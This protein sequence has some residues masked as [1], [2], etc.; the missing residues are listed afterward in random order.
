MFA[1]TSEAPDRKYGMACHQMLQ[2]QQQQQQQQQKHMKMFR[3]C[4]HGYLLVEVTNAGWQEALKAA[5][6]AHLI[7]CVKCGSSGSA[8]GPAFSKADSTP[9]LLTTLYRASSMKPALKSATIW[10]VKPSP[11]RIVIEIGRPSQRAAR[12]AIT[13]SY[14]TTMPNTPNLQAQQESHRVIGS[15]MSGVGSQTTSNASHN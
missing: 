11:M 8:P 5:G 2:G 6:C 14:R 9:E 3:K 13:R 10:I 1:N 7:G 15:L 4:V 12:G